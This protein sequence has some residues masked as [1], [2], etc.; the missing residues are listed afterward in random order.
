MKKLIL[1]SGLVFFGLFIFITASHAYLFPHDTRNMLIDFYDFEKDGRIYYRSGVDPAVIEELKEILPLAEDRIKGLYGDKISN[2]KIIYCATDEDYLK[3]GVPIL[4]PA[5]ARIKIGTYMVISKDGL[6]LDIIA[7]EL[8]HVELYERIGLL[9]TIMDMQAW[10]DEGLAMQ[11]D[12]RDYYSEETL[13]SKTNN[14]ETLPDVQAMKNYQQ[15]GA[16][17]KEQVKL[18]YMTARYEIS[19]WYTPEKLESFLASI[20]SGNTL[21]QS[22]NLK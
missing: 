1:K 18:N 5:C 21:E 15:F 13:R 11:V 20:N 22:F 10:F 4:T 12:Y 6:A 17:T 19:R 2:P 9:N 7:H 3:F 16:G 14:L 8:A